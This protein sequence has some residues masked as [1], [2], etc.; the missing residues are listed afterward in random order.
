[1]QQYG[2]LSKH[3]HRLGQL[4]LEQILLVPMILPARQGNWKM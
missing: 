1:M 4:A 2:E 3:V